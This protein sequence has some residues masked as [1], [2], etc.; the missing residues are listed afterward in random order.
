MPRGMKKQLRKR[1][2]QDPD[3]A[4]RDVEFWLS[5]PAQERIEA[6]EILR[7]QHHGTS[8]RIKKVVQIV[9]LELSE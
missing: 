2:L 8:Q 9:P 1:D 7:E 5:R 4:W 3:A 6:V